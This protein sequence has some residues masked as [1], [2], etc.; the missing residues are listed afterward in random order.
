MLASHVSGANKTRPPPLG[1]EREPGPASLRSPCPLSPAHR[2][3]LPG[4]LQRGRD[5]SSLPAAAPAAAR[6]TGWAPGPG[7]HALV[8][9]P[10]TEPGPGGAA[11]RAEGP[12]AAA[13][14]P[15][16]AWPSSAQGRSGSAPARLQ[17]R[18]RRFGPGSGPEASALP[19]L[20]A[21]GNRCCCC[22]CCC[23]RQL[24]LRGTRAAALSGSGKL[25]LVPAPADGRS[26]PAWL[27]LQLQPRV[28]SAPDAARSSSG[29][30]T[31]RPMDVPPRPTPA[32]SGRET[33]LLLTAPGAFVQL[34][35]C[36]ILGPA[37]TPDV[38]VSRSSSP[39]APPSSA[40]WTLEPCVSS[41]CFQL[42]A[43]DARLVPL[44]LRGPQLGV[45]AAPQL[46][47]LVTRS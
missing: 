23:F 27:Q 44:P 15:A 4:L 18:A 7:S 14:S 29:S 41:C 30:S 17:P 22:C 26:S 25:R 21:A 12:G 46:W 8:S 39:T 10:G 36:V 1:L 20:G 6:G 43:P 11:K 40:Q 42:Q 45:R 5:P 28:I 2:Q 34:R 3:R 38:P 13:P 31:L 35:P 24:R 33:L 16:P 19:V 47:G 9:L 32:R 37:E